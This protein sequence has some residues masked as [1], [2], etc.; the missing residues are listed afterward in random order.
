MSKIDT[1]FEEWEK[2]KNKVNEK[3][4]DAVFAIDTKINLATKSD[5]H[6]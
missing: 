5:V 2:K 6:E 4:A 3:A 1:E